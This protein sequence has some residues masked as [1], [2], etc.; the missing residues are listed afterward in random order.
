MTSDIIQYF[1]IAVVFITALAYLFNKLKKSFSGK[2]S[3][4]KGC[5]CA[6]DTKQHTAIK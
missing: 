5:G 6:V 3:C 1:I 2:K 4:D